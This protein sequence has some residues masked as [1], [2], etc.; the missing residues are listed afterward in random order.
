MRNNARD[1]LK[2]VFGAALVWVMRSAAAL[3]CFVQRLF[4]QRNLLEAKHL[5]TA[6]KIADGLLFPRGFISWLYE[7]C[8]FSTRAVI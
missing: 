8:G 5:K 7:F 2:L 4:R 6:L 1:R 3:V